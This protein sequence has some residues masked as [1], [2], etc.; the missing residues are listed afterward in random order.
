M[1][2]FVRE[3]SSEDSSL[4]GKKEKNKKAVK[5]LSKTIIIKFSVDFFNV[6]MS[7]IAIAIPKP[8]IGPIRGEINIAP[9]TTG[10]ELAFNPTDATK[11][12]QINI[13]AVAP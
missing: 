1:S 5:T 8:N 13:H 2:G 11:I 12:E 3:R 6:S 10:I 7:L 9:I 4:R